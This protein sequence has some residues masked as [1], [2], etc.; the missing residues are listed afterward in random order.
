M[1]E[2]RKLMSGNSDLI[3]TGG[4]AAAAGELIK[5]A[6]GTTLEYLFIVSLPFLKGGDKL[7]A[8]MYAMIEAED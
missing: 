4:S 5:K 7:D 2:G 6:G 1:A 8:P 3:A